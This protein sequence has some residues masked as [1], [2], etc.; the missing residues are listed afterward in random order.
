VNY[1][2]YSE[3]TAAISAHDGIASMSS[4]RNSWAT[5]SDEVLLAQCEIDTY[6]ASGPGGQ[7]RN[8]T[9]S[10][11]RVRHPASGLITIAE[12]SRSQHENKAK[13]LVRLRKAFYLQLREAIQP[14]TV[15]LQPE[16]VAAKNSEGRID[17]SRRD[18]RF[19][20]AVGAALDAIDAAKA[21]MSDAADW[22]GVT[23]ANLIHFLE[24]D[25]KLWQQVNVLRARHGQKS[26]KSS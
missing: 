3:Q 6:R 20:P 5:A 23:T 18:A 14:E 16:W 7:K 10:A 9:S 12:E 2:H 11:V 19:W 4:Q 15:A 13:A 26:L 21:R 22:L 25:P 8:K 24:Q 1:E 17:L